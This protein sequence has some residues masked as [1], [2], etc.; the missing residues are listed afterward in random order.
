MGIDKCTT[1]DVSRKKIGRVT[2]GAVKKNDEMGLIVEI[3]LKFL[4][5][6]TIGSVY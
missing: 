5:S 1:L 2:I 3:I 4:R 6:S